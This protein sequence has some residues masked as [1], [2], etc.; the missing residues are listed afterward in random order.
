MPVLGPINGLHA[1]SKRPR[2]Q[3]VLLI[4]CCTTPTHGQSCRTAGSWQLQQLLGSVRVLAASI[5]WLPIFAAPKA[6]GW[7]YGQKHN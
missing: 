5:D 7:D 6:K 3:E 4:N 1:G 2:I